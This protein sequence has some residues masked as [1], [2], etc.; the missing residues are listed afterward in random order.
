[1]D[2][3]LLIKAMLAAAFR[4]GLFQGLKETAGV[5]FSCMD[6]ADER[7]KASEKLNILESRFE[8]AIVDINISEIEDD[9]QLVH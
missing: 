9:D 2:D 4:K 7:G 1:M 5:I 8:K 3:D 6:N